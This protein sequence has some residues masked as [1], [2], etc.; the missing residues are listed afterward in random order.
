MLSMVRKLSGVRNK[1]KADLVEQN[2]G[3]TLIF[4]CK[5]S[6]LYQGYIMSFWLMGKVMADQMIRVISMETRDTLLIYG[7]FLAYWNHAIEICLWLIPISVYWFPEWLLQLMINVVAPLII[8]CMAIQGFIVNVMRSRLLEILDV[9]QHTLF[10]QGEQQLLNRSF[11][12]ALLYAVQLFAVRR[13][14]YP[15]MHQAWLT[16]ERNII[17]ESLVNSLN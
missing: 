16:T 3:S 15:T 12:M 7:S 1:S 9:H 14:Y 8:I 6:H 11:G 5:L 13:R 4:A 2:V 10:Y 17:M